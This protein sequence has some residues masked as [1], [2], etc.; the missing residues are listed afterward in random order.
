MSPGPSPSVAP[1]LADPVGGLYVVERPTTSLPRDE[2]GSALRGSADLDGTGVDQDLPAGLS[3]LTLQATAAPP[4]QLTAATVFDELNSTVDVF[5]HRVGNWLAGLPGGPVST[6]LEGALLM[7]RRTLFNQAP[8]VSPVQEV[9]TS[10]G[11]IRG[12][13]GAIDPEADVLSFDVTGAP[14]FGEVVVDEFGGYTYTPGDGYT[15]SDRFTVTVAS[16]AG[17]INLLDLWGDGSREVTVVVGDGAATNPFMAGLP[18]PIDATLYLDEAAAAI[19][20][21]KRSGWM[22]SDQ[23]RATVALE[24]ITADT[25]L[26]WMDARGRLGEVSVGQLLT[27]SNGTSSNGISS[28]GTSW[29]DEFAEAGEKSL[30]GV[31]LGL[32][33]TDAD[34]LANTMILS[35]VTATVDAAG[36]YVFT[37]YLA[38]N[39]EEQADIDQWDVLGSSY[40]TSYETF[41]RTYVTGAESIALQVANAD[42]YASTFSPV[43]YA[44]I[45]VGT[46]PG[47][48]PEELGI[49]GPQSASGIAFGSVATSPVTVMAPYTDGDYFVARAD[50]SVQLRTAGGW[51]DLKGTGW[52]SAVTTMLPYGSG[53][54]VGLANGAVQ[55]WTGTSRPSQSATLTADAELRAGSPSQSSSLTSANG[56][57]T[58][59]LQNDGNLVLYGGGD[60]L[61]ASNTSGKGAT[62]L[63]LQSDGNLVLY[64][65][66]GD[67]VWAT[68]T[69]QAVRLTVQN[70]GNV[71]LYDA[72]NVAVWGAAQ[73]GGVNGA[74]G[75]YNAPFVPPQPWANN[76]SEL[77]GDWGSGVDAMLAYGDGFVVGLNDGSVQQWTGTE[78]Q[79]LHSWQTLSSES[80]PS[81]DSGVTS[82]FTVAN[83]TSMPVLIRDMPTDIAQGDYTAPQQSI[84]EGTVL[85]PGKSIDLNVR[86]GTFGSY[87][88]QT[89]WAVRKW[90]GEPSAYGDA[91]KSWNVLLKSGGAL[92]SNEAN[93]VAGDCSVDGLTVRLTDNRP[94]AESGQRYI[95]AMLPYRDG[96]VAALYDGTV[97]Q[98]TGSEWNVLYGGSTEGPVRSAITLGDGV[99]VG[100]GDGS[101]MQVTGSGVRKRLQGPGWG[102]AVQTMLPFGD[103]VVAG[104]ANG[105][106]QQWTGS[107]WTE[108]HDAGWGSGVTTMLP[109]GD[110][111]VVGLANGSVQQWTGSGWTELQGT[112]WATSIEGMVPRPVGP[113]GFNRFV[114]GLGDGSV[115]QWTGVSWAELVPKETGILSEEKLK[116]AVEFAETLNSD[117]LDRADT[118]YDAF[119]TNPVIWGEDGFLPACGNSCDGTFFPFLLKSDEPYELASKQWDIGAGG[120]SLKLSYDV[121]HVVYGYAYVPGGVW[122][123]LSLSKYSGGFMLALPT[124][125]RV[126]L[127]LAGGAS[128]PF[129][130][131][132]IELLSAS[133]DWPTPYGVFE[134][135]GDVQARVD[136]TLILPEDF[137]KTDLT[138]YAYF[139]PGFLVAYNTKDFQGVQLGAD[140]YLD[141]DFNDF[142]QIQGVTIEPSLTPSVNGKYGLFTPKKT[143]IIGQKTI[144]SVDLGYT[145][146]VSLELVLKL[147]EDPSLTFKSS[148]VLSYGA[149]I[150]QAFTDSLTF[151]DELEIYNYESPVPLGSLLA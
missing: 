105:S 128:E 59:T 90:S 25:A 38:P 12:S 66:S 42:L 27:A 101:V 63:D 69:N 30:D 93:C 112:G 54:V 96:F 28:N 77:H 141:Y 39:P 20:L 103:G 79:E 124:G 92:A 139:V 84:Q 87:Y 131:G 98:W 8:D 110:G 94:G 118:L 134:L 65:D 138:A 129:T 127:D 19:T 15:G 11:L 74:T 72:D 48:T 22:L 67:P 97:Q 121:E 43:T 151:N 102:S 123:K 150:L 76:W 1:V 114:V 17:G 149:G 41:L 29:W 33:F 117:D 34:G 146:P 21:D 81:N 126:V 73:N 136:A 7:V 109:F 6:F 26:S 9:T 50:G 36:G 142:L 83:D 113:A 35:N 3:T 58:M 56:S 111:F 106:V 4:P 37:G 137:T 108:L 64:T 32:D 45:L 75:N 89:N 119:T 2:R 145:N 23:Y 104:L 70:D 14:E 31:M 18:D 53:V 16:A 85:A 78:W 107:D 144:A 51:T 91:G 10:E 49:G 148:G 5:L 68:G 132:D 143:P 61:W 86:G 120:Q 99:V 57:Y 24:G 46:D 147:R 71:V 82:T 115:Q 116:A 55:Q 135:N 44:N 80:W 52:G 88:N 122:S 47:I 13:L 130:T 95:Q 133:K 100:F 125:P 62:R 40:K 140:W 60:A